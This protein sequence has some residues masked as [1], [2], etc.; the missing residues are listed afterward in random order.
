[1]AENRVESLHT[2]RGGAIAHRVLIVEDDQD[3]AESLKQ[4]L[5]KHGFEVLTARDAG[6]AH[7]T[8]AMRGP[9]FVILDLILS[10]ESGFEVCERIKHGN[11]EL[12]VLVLSV[13][14][15]PD[16]RNLAARVGADGYL[17]K[18]VE[19]DEL[20]AKIAEI[21]QERWEK[22]HLDAPDEQGRIR[23]V[24]SC[25]KKFRVGQVHKGRTMT[26]SDC[27]ATLVVPSHS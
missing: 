1:M 7:S 19:R 15:M 5:Q 21:A 11:A 24:C 8:I 12:P 27:G 23:F 14:D 25:G 13:I 4:L 22:S 20:L 16:A 9:D 17:T 18:P 6:Q 26:C 10:G 3:N 2:S